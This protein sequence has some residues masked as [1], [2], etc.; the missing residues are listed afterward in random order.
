MPASSSS[1]VLS[2]AQ[3]NRATLARQLLLER[4][5]SSPLKA[6]AQLGGLQAQVPRPPS[7]ALWSRLQDYQHAAL[8][9]L[10][11]ARKLVRAPLFRGTLHLVTAGDFLALRGALHEMLAGNPVKVLRGRMTGIDPAKTV[12]FGR[13]ALA[14][15]AQTFEALREELA[16]FNPKADVRAMA[17]LV[18]MSVPVVQL[19][20][21]D[22]WSFPSEAQFTTAAKWLGEEVADGEGLPGLVLRYLAAF[23]PASARDC[24]SWSGLQKL[25]P[26]FEA[27]RPKLVTFR[28]EAKRELFDLPKAPRPD[29][30][31]EAPV[32]LLPDYDSLVLAHDDRSRVVAREHRPALVTKNL[33]V[34]PTFLVD[35]RVAGTWKIERARKAAILQLAPFGPLK[36][37]IFRQLE[38]EGLRL[39]EF[40]EPEAREQ[41]V[42]AV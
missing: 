33:Q 13:A 38:E 39:L 28:D 17:Y 41:R 9:Q 10:L 3:L 8:H 4:S 26:V 35:G 20:S 31:V 1:T 12:A 16:V 15:R 11:H 22:A 14:K 34:K 18:R 27:L 23:G 21:G 42:T 5:R 24:Q 7:I 37:P 25:Q 2:L 30:E 32:R 29:P 6:V 36:K 40:A 19:P